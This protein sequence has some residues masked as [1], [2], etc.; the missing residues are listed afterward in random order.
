MDTITCRD[1]YIRHTDTNGNAAVRCHRV[2]DAKRFIDSQQ[3]EAAASN[4]GADEGAKRLA[5]AEQ[6]TEEQYRKER[7]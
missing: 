3:R 5:K 2:W 6:I 4:H 7:G 1:I